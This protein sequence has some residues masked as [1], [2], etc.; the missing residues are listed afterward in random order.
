MFE[1]RLLRRIFEPK[2]KWQKAGDDGKIRS[3]IDHTLYQ[4]FIW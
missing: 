1:K 3:F 4:I 2:R